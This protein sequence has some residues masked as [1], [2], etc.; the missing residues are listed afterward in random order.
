MHRS[1]TTTRM[2]KDRTGLRHGKLVVLRRDTSAPSR[3]SRWLCRCDCG[4]EKVFDSR[5]LINPNRVSCG[6]SLKLP[7]GEASFNALYKSYKYG[8]ERRNLSFSL[9]KEEFRFMVQRSCHYCGAQPSNEFVVSSRSKG[10]LYTNGAFTYNGLDRMDNAQGYT[11]E[12][13]VACCEDCN[14]AKR[15]MSKDQFL[16]LVVRIFKH[17]KLEGR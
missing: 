9:S 1:H 6:C 16:G 11:S 13:V 4:K 3:W 10:K 5:E 15:S 2:V 17:M 8:A 12:N 14:R 7:K